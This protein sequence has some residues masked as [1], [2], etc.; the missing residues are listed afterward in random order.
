[1]S[2]QKKNRFKPTFKQF[3]KLRENIQN[4]QKILKFK[5]KKWKSFLKFY[6]NKLKNFKKFKPLD[7]SRY[8]VTK[9][10]TRGVG[11][12]KRFRDTLQA[13]KR[14]RIF[15]GNLAKKYLKKKQ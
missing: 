14:F 7:H 13:S 12:N 3:L 5:K 10:G 4:R 15:Y 11:Y 1:M 2:L 6:I 8:F 9:Y